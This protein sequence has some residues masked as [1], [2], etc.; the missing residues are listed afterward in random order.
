MNTIIYAKS[1]KGSIK[2]NLEVCKSF[3]IPRSYW[4]GM[5]DAVC[6]RE[7]RNIDWDFVSNSSIPSNVAYTEGFYDGQ[8]KDLG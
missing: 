6:H 7:P 4:Q 5:H 1:L 2:E 8:H 3:P